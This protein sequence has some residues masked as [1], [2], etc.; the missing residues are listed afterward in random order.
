M[1]SSSADAA[2]TPVV[3]A[4]R[5]KSAVR[6][7]V[8]RSLLGIALLFLMVAAGVW[9]MDAGIEAEAD[10]LRGTQVTLTQ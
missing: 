8:K 2:T 4:A 3:A 9:L 7:V 10:G 1:S 6:S 5:R